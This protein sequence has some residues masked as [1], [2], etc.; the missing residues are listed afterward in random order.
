VDQSMMNFFMTQGP[1]ALLFVVLFYW[2]LKDKDKREQADK[3]REDKL[4]SHNDGYQKVLSDLN[5][6]Q[7]QLAAAVTEIRHDINRIE[8]RINERA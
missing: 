5:V 4:M 7:Q 8:E 3:D 2:T 1:W 6:G